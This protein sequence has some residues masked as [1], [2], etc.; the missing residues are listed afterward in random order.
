[1][2]LRY[3]PFR[4]MDRFT[5]QLFGAGPRRAWMPIDAVRRG[6]QV[7][8]HFDLPGVSPD[9]IDVSVED[10][11]LTV[12]ADRTWYPAEGDEVLARERVH[13]TSTRQLLLGD[14]LD[15]DRLEASYEHGV[16]TVRVPV[17]ERAKPR[18]VAVRASD[19]QA[20]EV[21]SG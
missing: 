6:D 8:V 3:D 10:N 20:V 16:L 21:T 12:R 11:V 14:S 9:D 2:L 5:E 17:A 15:P 13:G 18:K 19:P 4:E 7:E 1:M